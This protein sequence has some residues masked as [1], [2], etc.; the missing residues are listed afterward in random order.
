MIDRRRWK[1]KEGMEHWAE[2][3]VMQLEAMNSRT[4]RRD[5]PVPYGDKNT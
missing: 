1:E 2:M 5:S 3:E 4:S